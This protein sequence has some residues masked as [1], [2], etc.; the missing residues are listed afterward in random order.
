[1]KINPLEIGRVV[2]RAL[3]NKDRYKKRFE[4]LKSKPIVI[5]SGKAKVTYD[6]EK[7][8]I[9]EI[10]F[11]GLEGTDLDQIK[12]AVN[13]AFDKADSVWMELEQ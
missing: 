3:K 6:I 7:N 8:R 10:K 4:E 9:S 12:D 11:E 2:N 5:S 1:M 13:Q